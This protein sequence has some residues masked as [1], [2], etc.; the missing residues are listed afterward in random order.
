MYSGTRSGFHWLIIAPHSSAL[1][2]LQSG[3]KNLHCLIVLRGDVECRNPLHLLRKVQCNE[4]HYLGVLL[5]LCSEAHLMF[6]PPTGYTLML[7]MRYFCKENAH[8]EMKWWLMCILVYVFPSKLTH[9]PRKNCH[10]S[11]NKTFIM[12]KL[13]MHILKK[14]NILFN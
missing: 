14:I 5:M 6:K 10:E 2:S 7:K 8:N 1:W 11:F 12:K 4:L 13:L 3:S 9:L